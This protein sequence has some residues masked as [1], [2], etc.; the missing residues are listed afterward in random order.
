MNENTDIHGKQREHVLYCHVVVSTVT[1]VIYVF[2]NMLYV[3]T[4]LRNENTVVDTVFPCEA[5]LTVWT[6]NYQQHQMRFPKT[7]FVEM[8][9]L[10]LRRSKSHNSRVSLLRLTELHPL[11]TSRWGIS[12]S[13][14][15]LLKVRNM[16]EKDSVASS[17]SAFCS[18]YSNK[19]PRCVC[20]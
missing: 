9:C 20:P 19:N 1:I 15:L 2:A 4:A 10:W 3:P 13:A 16:M 6:V 5:S 12:A 8:W 14:L 7:S 17:S 18:F 11:Q